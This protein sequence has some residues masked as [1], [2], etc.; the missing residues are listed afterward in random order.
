MFERAATEEE[1]DTMQSSIQERALLAAVKSEPIVKELIRNIRSSS[2]TI[3]T[4]SAKVSSLF[5]KIGGSLVLGMAVHKWIETQVDTVISNQ[6]AACSSLLDKAGQ[7]PFQISLEERELGI[8]HANADANVNES[9]DSQVVDSR[10]TSSAYNPPAECSDFSKIGET[11][12]RQQPSSPNK[13]HNIRNDSNSQGNNHTSDNNKTVVG[14]TLGGLVIKEKVK[15]KKR[16]KPSLVSS[17]VTGSFNNIN[18]GVSSASAW[19]V[20]LSSSVFGSQESSVDILAEFKSSLQPG[21]RAQQHNNRNSDNKKNGVTEIDSASASN[22]GAIVD[23][24]VTVAQ[25]SSL[26]LKKQDVVIASNNT[27][28]AV[29]AVNSV[30]ASSPPVVEA[31][32]EDDIKAIEWMVDLYV[33]LVAGQQ[34]QQIHITQVLTLLS[35]IVG[36]YIPSDDSFPFSV[37]SIVGSDGQL[38]YPTLLT[39]KL[40]FS[41]FQRRFV[42]GLVPL[43]RCCGSEYVAQIVNAASTK[44]NFSASSRGKFTKLVD[45]MNIE[46]GSAAGFQQA[47][48]NTVYF[49]LPESF[50]KPFREE[51]DS[52]N[53]Y[54]KSQLENAIYNERERC[55]DEFSNLLYRF[56]SI[57]KSDVDGSRTYNFFQQ[58]LPAA[59]VSVSRCY[60]FSKSSSTCVYTRIFVYISTYLIF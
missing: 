44:H 16:M 40:A 3:V 41:S 5:T 18:G 36:V 32:I 12:K 34:Q 11:S 51:L 49:R 57:F 30:F 15:Q 59:G 20:P 60:R 13:N 43:I 48:H 23:N 25:T 6:T 19:G 58:E 31:R 35:K 28:T 53:E 4:D 7:Y 29:S 22:A 14:M 26:S 50:V 38:T 1:A 37:A 2:Y 47:S 27:E 8:S 39:S 52:R 21:K 10:G 54:N 17:A 42:E 33:S 9:V 45:A 46:M 56:Q 55:Y 24:G